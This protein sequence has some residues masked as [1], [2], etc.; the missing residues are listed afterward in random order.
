MKMITIDLGSISYP[1]YIS[2]NILGQLHEFVKKIEIPG[3]I[4]V[5]I[6]EFIYKK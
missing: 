4:Y 5:I 6:D 2:E 1:V 3:R